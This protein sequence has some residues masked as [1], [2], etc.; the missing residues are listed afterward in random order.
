MTAMT[1]R[2][3][4][5]AESKPAPPSAADLKRRMNVWL[6]ILLASTA[7]FV[8]GN[9]LASAGTTRTYFCLGSFVECEAIE[10]TTLG[11]LGI[12]LQWTTPIVVLVSALL[13]WAA[14]GI[15]KE[16]VAHEATQ[17]AKPDAERRTS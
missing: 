11:S 14:R 3:S 4:E 13:W 10:I 17:A 12:F 9:V 5:T 16:E 6:W 2:P 1:N 8:V 7:G 15:W